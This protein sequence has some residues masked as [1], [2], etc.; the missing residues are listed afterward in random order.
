MPD[1]INALLL[2]VLWY[3]KASSLPKLKNIFLFMKYIFISL[4]FSV[5][6]LYNIRLTLAFSNYLCIDTKCKIFIYS[7]RSRGIK[8]NLCLLLHTYSS[9]LGWWS[10]LSPFLSW[11][12]MGLLQMLFYQVRNLAYFVVDILYTFLFFFEAF[13]SVGSLIAGFAESMWGIY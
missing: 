3:I 8:H 2:G 7:V 9:H 1:Q 4:C 11:A 13:L 5:N 12:S 10:S 6:G